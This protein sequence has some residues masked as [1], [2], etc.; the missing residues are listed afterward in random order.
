VGQPIFGLQSRAKICLATSQLL[1][2]LYTP[3]GDMASE[4]PPLPWYRHP[5]GV[6][7][8]HMCRTSVR[9]PPSASAVQP[10]FDSSDLSLGA[11][12][13]RSGS[14]RHWPY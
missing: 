3:L 9:R 13:R 12:R 5:I 4:P 6:L 8:P 10:M 2:F 11:G 7:Y 1:L 14:G